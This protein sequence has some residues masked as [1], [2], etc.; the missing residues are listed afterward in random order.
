MTYHP[1]AYKP[2]FAASPK[3][4]LTEDGEVRTIDIDESELTFPPHG[5]PVGDVS[6]LGTL[7]TQNGTFS[8]TSS[9]TNTGDQTISDATISTTDITTNNVSTSKHGFAPKGD[10]DTAKFLNADGA[11]STPAGG[12][13]SADITQV[14]I[15]FGPMAVRSKTFTVTDALVTP[16][17]QII[18][19]QAGDAPTGKT[20]DDN[21]MDSIL[22]RA[23]PGS[24][25]FT[26]YATVIEGIKV[27]GFYRCNYLRG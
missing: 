1:I 22:F 10:G 26:L 6:G 19:S 2:L 23:V 27:N 7:A 11:Y 9:G 14:E 5:H 12:G 17:T 15:D 24:G 25:Q 16:S 4:V 18:A 21:E 8:G 20:A 3:I 13:G